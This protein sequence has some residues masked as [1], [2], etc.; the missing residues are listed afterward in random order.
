VKW[1]KGERRPW[2]AALKVAC[3]LLGESF[4]KVS[5]RD[6][7]VYGKLYRQRKD[8]EIA[9][10]EAGDNAESAKEGLKKM[11]APDSIARKCYE[12]GKLPPAQIHARARRW[13]VKLFLSHLHEFWYL[14]HHGKPAPEPYPI[15]WLGHAHKVENPMM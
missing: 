3:Y 12:A 7:A 15:V 4:V 5:G 11:K 8:Y 14:H 9:R 6:D 10:N 13:T 1:A 2:C